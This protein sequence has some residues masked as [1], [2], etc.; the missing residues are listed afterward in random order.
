VLVKVS[1]DALDPRVLPEMGV[2]V[3]FLAD[4]SGAGGTGPGAA[5]G[6]TPAPAVSIPAAAVREVQGRAVVFVVENGRAAMRGVS[7]RTL[8]G[9]RVAVTGG[10]SP[11]EMVVVEAPGALADNARVKVK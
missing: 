3:M 6:A 2:K 8:A 11:G 9:D 4:D 5:S 1:F 10:L 7:P